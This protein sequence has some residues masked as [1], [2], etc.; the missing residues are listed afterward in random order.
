[1]SDSESR[2]K[3]FT[4]VQLPAPLCEKIQRFIDAHDELGYD[5]L[6]DFIVTAAREKMDRYS[7]KPS[8]RR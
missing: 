1:M 2:K 8:V 4:T 7:T 5:D 3:T 6:T